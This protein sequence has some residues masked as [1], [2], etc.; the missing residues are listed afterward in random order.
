MTGTLCSTSLLWYLLRSALC[1]GVKCAGS[2]VSLFFGLF[3]I[4]KRRS[5]YSA[6]IV[7]MAQQTRKRKPPRAAQTSSLDK[8]DK[9]TSQHWELDLIDGWWENAKLDQAGQTHK[10]YSAVLFPCLHFQFSIPPPPSLPFF[11]KNICVCE[12]VCGRRALLLFSVGEGKRDC[13]PGQRVGGME[14]WNIKLAMKG[15]RELY[16]KVKSREIRNNSLILR[17]D[18]NLSKLSCMPPLIHNSGEVC[19]L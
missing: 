9:R 11:F 2:A 3:G 5:G 17:I 12:R 15:W 18:F 16:K 4:N 8:Q 7:I 1:P 13:E 10:T 6:A 19:L 14:R